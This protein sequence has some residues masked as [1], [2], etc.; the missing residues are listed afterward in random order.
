MNPNRPY[1]RPAFLRRPHF[2]EVTVDGEDTNYA[3]VV[4]GGK[5]LE[6]VQHGLDSGALKI[7]I[8]YI[9]T[10]S[11]LRDEVLHGY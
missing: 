4:E 3:T 1:D 6:G 11:S 2:Y 5:V 10:Y 7:T 9:G 8:K